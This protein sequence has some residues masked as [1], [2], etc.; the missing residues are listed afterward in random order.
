MFYSAEQVANLSSQ[1]FEFLK[2]D[3]NANV[4]RLTLNRPE[5]KNA[6]NPTLLNEMAFALTHAKHNNS[7]WA[8]VMAAEGN[9]FCAGADLM[10]FAGAATEMSSTI[11]DPAEPIRLVEVFATLYKPCIARVHG[12]VYAGGFMIISG[13]THVIAVE[14]ATFS[15]PEVKRGLWPFQVMAGLMNVMPHRTMLDLC[16]RAGTLTAQQAVNSGLVTKTVSSVEELDATINAL[17]DD[18]K[19]YSPAAIRKGLEAYNTMQSKQGSELHNYM[20]EMLGKTLET[21][22]AQEGLKAFMEKRS[23]VWTGE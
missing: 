15:L 18:I 5:K 14:Q 13:C 22:D 19:Q 2:V 10:S 11:P 7:V 17:V 4:L 23:P 8:V 1:R 12:P 16:M 3:F 9:V 6:M 20:F 21:K